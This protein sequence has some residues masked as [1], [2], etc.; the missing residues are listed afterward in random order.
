MAK[1]DITK[2]PTMMK[3]GDE[4]TFI[5][6]GKTYC[7][8]NEG[9]YMEYLSGPNDAI[10]KALKLDS[11]KFA[12]EHKGVKTEVIDG[13]CEWPEFEK[14]SQEGL[15]N[16]VNAL[17]DV[18]CGDLQPVSTRA[19]QNIKPITL[20][21]TAD[22]QRFETRAQ[23]EL[24]NAETELRQWFMEVPGLPAN[25][26]ADLALLTLQHWTMKRKAVFNA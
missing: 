18:I 24:H 20:F 5:A 25:D 3:K 7:Y 6:K 15:T 26:A 1:Y 16:I 10:F 23:A 22:G 4:V 8:F 2:R 11:T 14:S 21:E 19:T 13:G 9:T 17:F 12:N